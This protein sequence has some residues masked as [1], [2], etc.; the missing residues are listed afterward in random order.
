MNNN[1]QKIFQHR[2]NPQL[3]Y[4]KVNM[5][6]FWAWG[7][8]YDDLAIVRVRSGNVAGDSEWSEPNTYGA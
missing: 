8:D 5:S 6:V 2:T 3:L 1:V 4:C 7:L